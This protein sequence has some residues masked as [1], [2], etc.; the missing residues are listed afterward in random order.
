[1]AK[2]GRTIS[3]TLISKA[4]QKV[5]ILNWRLMKKVLKLISVLFVFHSGIISLNSAVLSSPRVNWKESLNPILPNISN[6]N[7]NRMAAQV[8][9]TEIEEKIS[10]NLMKLA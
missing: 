1:M 9:A 8:A 6:S 3:L 2:L 5:P 10:R 4:K 7:Q